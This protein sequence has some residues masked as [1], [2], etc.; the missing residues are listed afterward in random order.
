MLFSS[1]LHSPPC[2]PT[3]TRSS[4]TCSPQPREGLSWAAVGWAG[5]ARPLL[6]GSYLGV[7]SQACLPGH[8]WWGWGLVH[9]PH[10]SFW[11]LLPAAALSPGTLSSA[12]E[13]KVQPRGHCPD[14]K[15]RPRRWVGTGPIVPQLSLRDWRRGAALFI[16]C[17]LCRGGPSPILDQPKSNLRI[18]PNA[19]S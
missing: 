8:S 7:R 16:R 10:L 17:S 1:S 14:E 19:T 3:R 4:S 18:V 5:T 12:L 13:G 15:K 2:S 6:L 11:E 9:L